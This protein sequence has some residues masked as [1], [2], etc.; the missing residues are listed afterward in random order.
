MQKYKCIQVAYMHVR[1][2]IVF[3]KRCILRKVML[4]CSYLDKYFHI[5]GE[6]W[7][8]P[9]KLTMYNEFWLIVNFVGKSDWMSTDLGIITRTKFYHVFLKISRRINPLKSWWILNENQNIKYRRKLRNSGVYET[10]SYRIVSWNMQI[11]T[12]GNFQYAWKFIRLYSRN[13]P[14]I[15]NRKYAWKYNTPV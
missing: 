5:A 3:V 6:T 10:Y 12:P 7:K 15:K 11:S 1:Y 9:Q 2:I 13:T 8:I 4:I 14:T